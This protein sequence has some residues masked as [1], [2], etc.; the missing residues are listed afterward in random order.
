MHNMADFETL[1]RHRSEMARE[2]DDD[3]L[4]RQLRAAR[5]EKI[6]LA[7]LAGRLGRLASG[8]PQAAG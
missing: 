1:R 8:A 5:P 2:I 7:R 6:P 3:R 4:G